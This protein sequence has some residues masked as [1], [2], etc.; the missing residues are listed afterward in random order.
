VGVA[1]V[2][3]ANQQ[4]EK[5]LEPIPTIVLEIESLIADIE[6]ELDDLHSRVNAIMRPAFG[7]SSVGDQEKA[8]PDPDVPLVAELSRL[9]SRLYAIRARQLDILERI[10]L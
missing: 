4:P 8:Q 1:G 5:G 3:N 7:A 9:A 6:Q 2:A 10:A